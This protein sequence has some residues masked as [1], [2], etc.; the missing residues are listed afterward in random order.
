MER[1]LADPI[2]RYRLSLISRRRAQFAPTKWKNLQTA[3]GSSTKM[4][5][6]FLLTNEWPTSWEHLRLK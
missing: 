1:V 6:L 4:V 5:K 3:Y 2:V